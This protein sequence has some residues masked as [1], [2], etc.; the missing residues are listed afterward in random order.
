MTI[1]NTL[2]VWASSVSEMYSRLIIT[3]EETLVQETVDIHE[4]Y[5]DIK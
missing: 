2:G 1:C 4:M 3:V 5:K